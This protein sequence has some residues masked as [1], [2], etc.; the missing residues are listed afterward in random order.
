MSDEYLEP[1]SLEMDEPKSNTNR[2]IIAVVV[3]VILCICLCLCVFIL[4]PTLLG[5]MVG[6]VFSEIEYQLLTPI[7]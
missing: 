1:I 5:P 6:D 7:P 4:I 3:A 2:I